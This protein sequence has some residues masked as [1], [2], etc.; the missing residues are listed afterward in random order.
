[1]GFW[2]EDGFRRGRGW[3]VWVW[4]E[5]DRRVGLVSK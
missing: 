5:M 3:R 2:G 4:E 1:M